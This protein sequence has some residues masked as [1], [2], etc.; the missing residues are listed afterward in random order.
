VAR[1][2]VVRASAFAPGHVTGLFVPDLSARDPRARGARGAGLVLADG[3]RADATWTPAPR[4][5]IRVTSGG[6]DAGPITRDVA[7]RLRP[8]EPGRLEVRLSHALPVGQGFGMS[9]AGA[10]ATALAVSSLSH[11]PVQRAIE[12]A[13]LADLFGGGGLGGVAAI[14][15]GGLERRVRPGVPPFGTIERRPFSAPVWIGVVGDPIPSPGI[16]G[17]RRRMARIYRAADGLERLVAD[18]SPSRFLEESERFTDR[19]GVATPAVRR[20]LEGLRRRGARASQAMFGNSF[21]AVA[22]RPGV[23]TSVAAYLGRSGIPAAELRVA[24]RGAYRGGSAVRVASILTGAP[25][26]P[27]P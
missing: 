19:A 23:R 9:A 18:P 13:H 4:L 6:R 10:L 16:L 17:D 20:V 5:R 3:V 25:S 26:R 15:G 24:R 14:L 8:A 22:P 11:A 27:R 1:S 12:V 21:F 2:S 7:S